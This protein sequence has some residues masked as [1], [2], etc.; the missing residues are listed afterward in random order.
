MKNT[1]AVIMILFS[2]V[3]VFFSVYGEALYYSTKPDVT[4]Y[5]VQNVWTDENGVMKPIIPKECVYEGVYVYVV[6]QTSGFSLTINTVSKKE[7]EI[8][9]ADTDDY[10]I[11]DNG[12]SLGEVIVAKMS[13]ELQDGDRVNC[14]EDLESIIGNITSSSCS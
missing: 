2:A 9:D 12:L 8:A 14:V 7:V 1:V 11:V 3:I 4:V 10:I 5:R 13:E 6:T